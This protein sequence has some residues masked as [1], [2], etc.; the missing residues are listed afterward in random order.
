[1]HLRCH[2]NRT[3]LL[4]VH[5]DCVHCMMPFGKMMWHYAHCLVE[6]SK[7]LGPEGVAATALASIAYLGLRLEIPDSLN[8]A[9]T[10][11]R[12]TGWTNGTQ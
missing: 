10:K 4:V 6:A 1:M 3:Q 8:K 12:G 2:A 7:N 5:T 9:K 11:R